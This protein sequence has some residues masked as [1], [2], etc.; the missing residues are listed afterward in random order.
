VTPAKIVNV[1]AP[2]RRVITLSDRAP[3]EI[4]TALWPQLAKASNETA[5]IRVRRHADGRA[6]VYGVRPASYNTPEAVR[7][8]RL[9][10]PLHTAADLAVAVR[11]T[12]EI[13]SG[14]FAGP[15]LAAALLARLTPEEI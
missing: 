14:P 10:V 15:A 3:V 1:A 9:L 5:T 8:G 2:K 7:A 11:D 4:D 12:A 13:L 6:L